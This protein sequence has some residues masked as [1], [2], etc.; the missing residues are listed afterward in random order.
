[1]LGSI[2]GQITGHTMFWDE[3]GDFG[4]IYSTNT[5]KPVVH[6]PDRFRE[7]TSAISLQLQRTTTELCNELKK[8]RK[9]TGK[10]F[11]Y[12]AKLDGLSVLV[13][14]NALIHV[15]LIPNLHLSTASL[16]HQKYAAEEPDYFPYLQM[17]INPG[18][19][20]SSWYKIT[21]EAN[22]NINKLPHRERIPAILQNIN[23]HL[24]KPN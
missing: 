1:M 4:R 20:L 13:S 6:I 3:S 2:T 11:T 19:H 21:D 22:R 7:Q 23:R 15:R 12:D 18:F 5:S 17:E 8:I 9:Q 10:V 16:E 24:P 14:T